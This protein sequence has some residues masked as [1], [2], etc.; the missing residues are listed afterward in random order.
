MFFNDFKYVVKRVYINAKAA[1]P[2]LI[3]NKR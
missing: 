3:L 1:F 2:I